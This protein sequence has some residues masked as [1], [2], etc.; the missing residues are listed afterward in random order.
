MSEHDP[1]SIR[2]SKRMADLG[3]C[4]RREADEFIAAGQVLVDGVVVDVLG[5]RVLLTQQ[6]TLAGEASKEL[7]SKP[8]VVLNKPLGIVSGQP[9]DGYHAAVELITAERRWQWDPNP[10]PFRDS[11]RKGLA[12]AGR[13]DIDS[14]GL[15]LL[16]ADGRVARSIVDGSGGVEKEYLV[17]FDGRLN[18]RA[19]HALRY[20]LRLDDRQLRA[21]QV[22]WL[23]E[24]LL[25][26]VLREGRKR[27]IRRMLE[28]VGLRVYSLRRVRIGNIE[29]GDLP[30]GTWRLLGPDERP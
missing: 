11:D 5:S 6:V 18:P 28:L 8:T 15:L 29:L 23:E 9:E 4:S 21:A 7:Q 16:T 13:L 1:N 20:G 19:L 17:R 22:E 24:D 26:F 3:M 30:I 25:Q 12:V 14:T 2:L 27:Q 10:M